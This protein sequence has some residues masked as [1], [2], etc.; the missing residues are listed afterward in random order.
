M[1]KKSVNQG[2]AQSVQVRLKQN[3][4]IKRVAV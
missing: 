2:N 1:L 3:V 4:K